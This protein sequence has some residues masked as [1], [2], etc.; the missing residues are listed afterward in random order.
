[1][2]SCQFC[3]VKVMNIKKHN[4]TNKCLRN[5]RLF[6]KDGKK[7]PGCSKIFS[8]DQKLINHK[9]ICLK[10]Q[11]K[12][13]EEQKNNELQIVFKDVQQQIKLIKEQKIEELE[14]L[15]NEKKELQNKIEDLQKINEKLINNHLDEI[16]DITHS[17]R[18]ELFYIRGKLDAQTEVTTKFVGLK[19]AEK[20]ITGL[21]KK[22][23]KKQPREIYPERNVVYII[24]NPDLKSRRS[25][26]IG[27]ATN[28]TSRLSTYNK[29]AEHEVIF[30]QPCNT[31]ECM[32]M[33]ESVVLKKMEIYK[34][35]AN[36]DRI[37]LPEKEKI[38]MF[39]K[40]ITD[41]HIFVST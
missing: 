6:Y 14:L 9:L 11:I 38:D 29:S 36:R 7:C 21:E 26:I 30:F 31:K 39:I 27:K 40:I 5:R 20:R 37:I 41:T 8:Q 34:E 1:M 10:Y 19:K 2:I 18:E 3:D 4:K 35:V 25:Y 33:V 23:L 15:Q 13:V 24:T 32:N 28:L 16:K 22:Y 12:V 17:L